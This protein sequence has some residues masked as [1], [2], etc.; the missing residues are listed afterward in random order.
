[1][2]IETPQ[3]KK[4]ITFEKVSALDAWELREQLKRF[5]NSDDTSLRRAY[6][7]RVLGLASVALG[8]QSLGLKTSAMIDNHLCSPENVGTVFDGA[9]AANG[10][11]V[12]DCAAQT[13]YMTAIGAEMATSFVSQCMGALEMFV[14]HATASK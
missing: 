8:K 4:T 14:H 9:L 6:V 3:G 10:I 1:M 11:S 7:Q 13:E 5:L 12:K 2:E